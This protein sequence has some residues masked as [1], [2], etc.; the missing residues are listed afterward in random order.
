MPCDYEPW[1]TDLYDPDSIWMSDAQEERYRV[2]EQVIAG[3]VAKFGWTDYQKNMLT[4]LPE[5]GGLVVDDMYCFTIC[6]NVNRIYVIVTEWDADN[7]LE[8]IEEQL[9]GFMQ[10]LEAFDNE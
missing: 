1:G 6:D 2:L 5:P 9:V 4:H 7:K 8:E 3:W 10:E